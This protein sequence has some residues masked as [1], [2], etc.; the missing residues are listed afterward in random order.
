MDLEQ[1]YKPTFR[2]VANSSDVTST[3]EKYFMSLSLTDGTGTTS[4]TLEITL[5]DTDPENP[6][7]IPPKGSE[8][9]LFLGYGAAVVSM[10]MF[11]RDEVEL[12]GWPGEMVIRARAAVYD[13]TPKGKTNLQSQKTRSWPKGT[14]LGAMVKK[15]A[16]EHGM[17]SVVSA[18][19]ASIVLPHISQSDESDINLLIR[20]AKKYDAVAKPAGGKLILAKRGESKT[21]SG[22]ELP[23]VTVT[24]DQCGRYR[25]VESARETAGTVVAYYHATKQAKRHEVKI[26]TGEPVK[27]LK[28]YYP[29]QEMALAAARSE[30]DKRERGQETIAFSCVGDTSIQAE[31][32]LTMK[33]FRPGIAGDWVITRVIHTLGTGGY[34]CDVEAEK[35]NDAATPNATDT[36]E[37]E[38]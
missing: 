29:T 24:P 19:L 38:G 33:D 25:Y 36:A 1:K 23:V 26:G 18:K 27:R 16:S 34:Q 8:L 20:I 12:G 31:A 10:G 6:L 3:I 35:P 5:A 14:K 13:K 32:K 15:I 4:D 21:A 7:E 11:V 2:I 37:D 9:E 28:M 30:L 22:G 17:E